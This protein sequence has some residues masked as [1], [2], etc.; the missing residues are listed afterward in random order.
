VKILVS[1]GIHCGKV[2][3]PSHRIDPDYWRFFISRKSH[4]DFAKIIGSWHPRKEKI[5]EIRMKI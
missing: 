2:H 1:F 4:N 5:L 3:N